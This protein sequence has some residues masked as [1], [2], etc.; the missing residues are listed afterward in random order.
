MNV[1][2]LIV[3]LNLTDEQIAVRLV[4]SAQSVSHWR[5]GRSIPRASV[6]RKLCRMAGV[7]PSDVEWKVVAT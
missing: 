7:F 3:S 5:L 4:V 2:Q 1:P 6:R